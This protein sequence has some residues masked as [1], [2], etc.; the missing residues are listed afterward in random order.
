MRG[1][2]ADMAARRVRSWGLLLALTIVLVAVMRLAHLPAALMLGPMVAGIVVALGAPGAALPRGSAL[3]AQAVLGCLIAT[4]LSPAL[5]G[6]LAGRWPVLVGMNLLTIL[7]SLGLGMAA[8]RLR[9]LPGTAGIWGMSPGA[10][11]TMVLLSDAHGGDKRLVAVMQY[12]RLLLATAGVMAVGTLLGTPHR[13]QAMLAIPGGPNTRWL[14]IP[15]APETAAALALAIS[16]IAG[17][18]LL[19][20]PTVAIF[21]PIFGGIAVQALGGPAPAPPPLLAAAA[22]VVVGWRVGLSFTLASLLHIARLMPRVLAATLAVLLLCGAVAGL[23]TLLTPVGF[24]TAYMALNPGGTDVVMAMAANVAVDLP[25][26]LAMQVTRLVMVIALAP[27]L[28]RM[29]AGRHLQAAA[30]S[31]DGDA[32]DELAGKTDEAL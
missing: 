30:H 29:A 17:T 10:A 2:P 9:W 28:A 3:A 15:A 11:S 13:A 27:A 14:A 26:I 23:M 7:G 1:D 25:L 5:V 4:A 19:R 31:R 32:A 22:F 18:M 20:R 12:L 16:G 8:T 24:L 6:A 21:L